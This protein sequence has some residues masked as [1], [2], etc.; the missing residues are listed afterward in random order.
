MKRCHECRKPYSKK[1]KML[2]GRVPYLNASVF[3][4]RV[5]ATISFKD[6]GDAVKVCQRCINR[7]AKKLM[8]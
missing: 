3:G 4:K 7:L 2:H 1:G 8:E 6:R 5:V